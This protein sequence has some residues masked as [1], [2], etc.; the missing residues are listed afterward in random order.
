MGGSP[1]I[2]DMDFEWVYPVAC[3]SCSVCPQHITDYDRLGY[4]ICPHC[5]TT[6]RSAAAAPAEGVAASQTE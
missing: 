5:G 1:E 6:I 4:P 2:G 3:P